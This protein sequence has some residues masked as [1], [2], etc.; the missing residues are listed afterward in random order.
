MIFLTYCRL[1]SKKFRSLV[2]MTRAVR[3]RL[4]KMEQERWRVSMSSTMI[5]SSGVLRL[6]EEVTIATS[7]FHG[8]M[9]VVCGIIGTTQSGKVLLE[10]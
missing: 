5:T 7:C 1:L 8:Q 3:I 9:A 4:G 10:R 2:A 6:Y